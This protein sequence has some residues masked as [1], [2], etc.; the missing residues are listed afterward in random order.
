MSTSKSATLY[1]MVTPEHTCPYGLKSRALLRRKGFVVVDRLLTTRAATDKFE[2]DQHVDTT[3]QTFIGGRRIGG[4]DDLRRFFGLS[5]RQPG[6]PSY[7]PVLA[8]F[9]V[10]LLLAIAWRA[11]G[12]RPPFD[13]DLAGDFVATSMCIL[14]LLKLQDL[15]SFSTMFLNYDLLARRLVLYAYLYPFAELSA[16]ALMISNRLPWAAASMAGFIGLV[17]ASSVFKA[18]YI[19]HRALKCACVGGG[20]SVPLGVISLIEN[21]M[22]LGMAI[23]TI[24]SASR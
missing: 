13:M 21:L 22:M 6:A 12:G 1:R 5:V 7:R 8:V 11:G 14:A 23:A 18:V 15:E 19:D 16:G 10:A 20:S 24:V 3:P 9:A 17:G 4:Y 2:R